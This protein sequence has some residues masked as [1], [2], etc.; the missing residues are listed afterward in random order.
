MAL[1]LNLADGT[2]LG[3]VL[4]CQAGCIRIGTLDEL[5]DDLRKDKVAL[6]G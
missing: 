6:F 4:H 5:A 3:L 2:Q 1:L